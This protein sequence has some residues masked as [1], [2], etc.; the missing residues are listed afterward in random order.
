[1]MRLEV[2]HLCVLTA[3]FVAIVYTECTETPPPPDCRP[4]ID[5]EGRGFV[6]VTQGRAVRER[7]TR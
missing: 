4:R 7:R 2:M 5:Y 6:P 1:V 3:I